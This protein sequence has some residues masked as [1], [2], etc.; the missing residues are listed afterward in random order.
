[1]MKII[2]TNVRTG[3]AY[4]RHTSASVLQ[5]RLQSQILRLNLPARRLAL[6]VLKMMV[7]VKTL[8]ICIVR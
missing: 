2:K 1:M 6:V 7:Y 8:H 4:V 3:K 5:T